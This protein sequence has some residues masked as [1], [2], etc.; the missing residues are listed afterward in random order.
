M[1][2][3]AHAKGPAPQPAREPLTPDSVAVGA[4]AGQ[5]Q[6]QVPGAGCL[7][8]LWYRCLQQAVRQS[9]HLGKLQL[10]A[11]AERV[12]VVL[13][14]QQL[15]VPSNG[16]IGIAMLLLLL[17]VLLPLLLLRLLLLGLLPLHLLSPPVPQS[18]A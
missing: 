18:A 5:Q 14:L 16:V 13:K 4:K 8:C 6:R 1:Q 2:V 9:T 12:P 17:H 11:F 15:V 7:C 3:Q 10:A